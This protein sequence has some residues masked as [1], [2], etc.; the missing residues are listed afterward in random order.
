MVKV[1]KTKA[2]SDSFDERGVEDNERN[3]E[4]RCERIVVLPEPDSPL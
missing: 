3:D 4:R 2:A 1:S